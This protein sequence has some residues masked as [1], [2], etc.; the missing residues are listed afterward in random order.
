MV[1]FLPTGFGKS[2]EKRF[3]TLIF[4]I[5]LI[6]MHAYYKNQYCENY[7]IQYL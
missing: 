7:G 5:Y 2:G 6:A 4:Q 1:V 3:A